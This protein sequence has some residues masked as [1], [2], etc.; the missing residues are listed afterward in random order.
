MPVHLQ[1]LVN[2]IDIFVHLYDEGPIGND[3]TL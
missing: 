3:C 2:S 1:E